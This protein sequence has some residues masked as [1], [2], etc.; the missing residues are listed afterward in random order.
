MRDTIKIAK[1][2]SAGHLLDHRRALY[3]TAGA[4]GRGTFG[5]EGTDVVI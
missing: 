2:S 4:E 1:A 3:I 5:D